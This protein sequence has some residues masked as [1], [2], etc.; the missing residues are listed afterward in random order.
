M[1]AH[2]FGDGPPPVVLRAVAL[3][4]LSEERVE[5]FAGAR[6]GPLRDRGGERPQQTH[7]L[8]VVLRPRGL[9][10]RACI[11]DTNI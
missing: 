2:L 6:D 3:V 8:K 7:L 1:T 4:G 9:E 10:G 11:N 5:G